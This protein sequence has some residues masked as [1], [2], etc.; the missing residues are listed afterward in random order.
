MKLSDFERLTLAAQFRILAKVDSDEGWSRFVE[1]LES[2]YEAEY[3]RLSDM[4]YKPLSKEECGF[5]VSILA[6]YDALQRPYVDAYKDIPAD[7]AFPGFNGNNHAGLLGYFRFLLDDGRFTYLKLMHEDGN[8]HGPF[9]EGYLR[10][11]DEWRKRGEPHLLSGDEAAA[12]F[13]SR[14]A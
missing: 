13:E 14:R 3:H 12:V 2:G 6:V 1:I 5:V 7:L 4:L 10:M 11:V 8:S 9:E